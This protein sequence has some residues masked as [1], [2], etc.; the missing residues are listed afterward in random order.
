[1]GKQCVGGRTVSAG[2]FFEGVFFHGLS[3]NGVGGRSVI[4]AEDHFYVF[5]IMCYVMSM[6]CP[7]FSSCRSNQDDSSHACT[8]QRINSNQ[9]I[10]NQQSG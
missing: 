4:L 10:A 1:M 2:G 9:G 8:N 7:V 3:G 5:L 6:Y